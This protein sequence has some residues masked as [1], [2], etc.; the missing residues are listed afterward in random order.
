MQG[1][2]TTTRDARGDWRPADPIAL[3]PTIAWPPRPRA[4]ARWLLG[5]P[6]YLWPMNALWLATT[7]AAWAWLTPDLA[8]MRQFEA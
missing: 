1:S 8:T 6:G 4:I 5:F 7:L 2:G 3:P